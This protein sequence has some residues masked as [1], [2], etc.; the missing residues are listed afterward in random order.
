MSG[1]VAVAEAQWVGAV[2]VGIEGVAPAATFSNLPAAVEALWLALR[3]L[4]LGSQQY[5]AYALFFGEGA[6]ERVGRFLSRDG[7]LQLTFTMAGQS[8]LVWVRP[9]ERTAP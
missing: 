1:G 3:A 9:A 2:T 6:V 4:P 8:H 5:E 7:Q